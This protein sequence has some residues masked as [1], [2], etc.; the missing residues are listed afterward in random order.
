MIALKNL[1]LQY[2]EKIVFDD[3]SLAVG[4]GEKIGLIGKNGSGKST[5]F[6]I[7]GNK[8][9]IHFKGKIEYAGKPK[10]GYLPQ[11]LS[12]NSEEILVQFA[13]KAM[14]RIIS[15]EE[16]IEHL[17]DQIKEENGNGQSKLAENLGNLY[18]EYGRAGGYYSN[19]K[20]KKVLAGLGFTEQDMEKPISTFSGGWQIRAYLG[21]ILLGDDD[22]LLLDEPTNH[23]DMESVI[24]LENYLYK[25]KK[26]I[27]I[28]SHDYSFL[29]KIIDTTFSI[30]N[31][32]LIK[33]N[34]NIAS[35]EEQ[36]EIDILRKEKQFI[37]NQKKIASM[38]AFVNRFRYKASKAKQ[39]QSRLKRIARLREDLE[40]VSGDNHFNFQ[41]PDPPYCGKEIMQIN[42]AFFHFKDQEKLLENVTIDF[43]RGDKYALFGKNGTGKSTF[44]KLISGLLKPTRGEI[45]LHPS[46]KI[47]Y[48]A[49]HTIENLNNELNIY[50]EI[51]RHAEAN[52]KSVIREILG[53][54]MFSGDEQFK[55]IKNLSGGEKARVALAKLFV[56]PANFLILDEP[57][58]H[59]DIESKQVL[60]QAINQFTG[61]VLVISH[62]MDLFESSVEKILYL[63]ENT[64][65]KF[66]GSFLLF[67]EFLTKK[68]FTNDDS[69]NKKDEKALSNNQELRIKQ[70]DLNK[71]Q[72]RKQKEL[73]NIESKINAKEEQILSFKNLLATK[74]YYMDG[75]KSHTLKIDMA[76]AQTLIEQYMHRWEEIST[77]IDFISSELNM[78][79]L[80]EKEQEKRI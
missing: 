71:Q 36:R 19:S 14:T 11:E 34:G 47:G 65:K 16:D 78:I 75:Q 24:W 4:D 76:N 61:S 67:Q 46:A 5:L 58:N 20:T 28:I 48:F 45:H 23:L 8:K 3:T 64:I 2:N 54:F 10:I 41:F 33:Y 59:L 39:A 13:K 21:Q 49:Q 26:T 77:E 51:E 12:V 38:E 31:C 25:I 27:I 52:Y 40:D 63:E 60:I 66:E 9:D 1:S 43:Y 70:K 62:D 57:T 69:F 73:E 30:E 32:K 53:L 37:Q 18:E 50:D 7:I 68:I 72:K 35:Y 74:E 79:L 6:N 44:V 80:R 17:E 56:S 42:S 29:D 22:L 55:M 15:L